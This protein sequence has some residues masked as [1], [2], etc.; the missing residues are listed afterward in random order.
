ML[1]IVSSKNTLR[2]GFRDLGIHAFLKGLNVLDVCVSGVAT[3]EESSVHGM[4][5]A[6]HAFVV[7]LSGC[8]D[9]WLVGVFELLH[10]RLRAALQS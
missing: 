3:F 2:H 6:L 5:A 1:R 7:W 4:S 8:P 9:T 10:N